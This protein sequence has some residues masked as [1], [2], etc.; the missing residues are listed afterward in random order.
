MPVMH[1]IYMVFEKKNKWTVFCFCVLSVLHQVSLSGENPDSLLAYVELVCDIPDLTVWLDGTE[2]G[3]TP[4]STICMDQG[5]HH[6]AVEHAIPELWIGRPFKRTFDIVAGE[7]K[8]IHVTFPHRVWVGSDPPGVFIYNQNQMIGKTPTAVTIPYNRKSE[9]RLSKEGYKDRWLSQSEIS[10][11]YVHIHM[12]KQIS[13]FSKIKTVNPL[14]VSQKYWIF[15][16]GAVALLSGITGYCL[17]DGAD[18]SYQAYLKTGDPE[19]MN[20]YFRK[21]QN[22]D[23]L[24]SIFYGLGEACLGISLG[25]S[26]LWITSDGL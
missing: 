7:T 3:N 21:S 16:T 25:L 24:S 26:L 4:L 8:T 18:R 11:S 17:M 5:V 12:I 9:F 19:Q 20:R 6:I 2:I 15:G 22:R 14:S 1:V 13:D 23:R 10:S